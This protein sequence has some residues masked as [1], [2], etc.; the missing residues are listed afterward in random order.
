MK[1]KTSGVLKFKRASQT[2]IMSQDNENR[3]R[4]SLSGV[5]SSSFIDTEKERNSMHIFVQPKRFASVAEPSEIARNVG[6]GDSDMTSIRHAFNQV[7]SLLEAH[8]FKFNKVNRN[9]RAGDNCIDN[10]VKQASKTS[11]DQNKLFSNT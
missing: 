6:A 2:K 10:A 7:S 4:N 11:D 5:S 1:N 8:N 9:K 3:S